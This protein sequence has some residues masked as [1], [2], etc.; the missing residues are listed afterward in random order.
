[1]VDRMGLTELFTH[2]PGEDG[3]ALFLRLKASEE[4]KQVPII[5][6]STSTNL[7]GAEAQ[8]HAIRVMLEYWFGTALLAAK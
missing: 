8:L 5:F 7:M 2:L 6:F 1:M 3:R 4:L